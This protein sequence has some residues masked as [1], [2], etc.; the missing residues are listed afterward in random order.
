MQR[1]TETQRDRDTHRQ[2]DTERKTET[3]SDRHREREGGREGGRERERESARATTTFFL[4][5][6]FSQAPLL[7][8]ICWNELPDA[9]EAA[10]VSCITV[11]FRKPSPRPPCPPRPPKFVTCPPLPH[12]MWLLEGNLAKVT[13]IIAPERPSHFALPWNHLLY[14]QAMLRL[15]SASEI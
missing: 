14:E 3:E 10:C 13:L 1:E 12:S 6:P 5:P 15:R 7:I 2:A 9:S 11:P 8:I 4:L